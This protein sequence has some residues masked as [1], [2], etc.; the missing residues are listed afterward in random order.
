MSNTEDPIEKRSITKNG[1]FPKQSKAFTFIVPIGMLI[2]IG[3]GI[4]VRVYFYPLTNPRISASSDTHASNQSQSGSPFLKANVSPSTNI[5]VS[6]APTEMQN[7]EITHA[8]TPRISST[9]IQP[10]STPVPQPSVDDTTQLGNTFENSLGLKFVK[11]PNTVTYFC[12]WDTR[13]CDYNQFVSQTGRTWKEAGFP[14]SSD[15]PAVRISYIDAVAFCNWLTQQ[16]HS[17]EKLPDSLEYRLP[18]DLEW[19]VA[20]GVPEEVE[21]PP[22]WR[23]GAI[24]NCFAWGS[25]FPPPVGSGNYDPKLKT[26][27]YPYTSRVGSFRENRYGLFDMNGNVQ[28]WVLDDY[29]DSGQ[30]CLR[31]GS[32]ADEDQDGL[33][34]TT[35]DNEKKDTAYKV[36]G[37]RCVLAPIN[38]ISKIST[39][40]ITPASS[41][42]ATDTSGPKQESNQLV[43]DGVSEFFKRW[44]NDLTSNNPNNIANNFSDGAFYCYGNGF[45]KR[46]DICED[47]LKLQKK[48]P[49]RTYSDI[50]VESVNVE[51]PESVAI[52]YHIDYQY[53][54]QKNATG[55][56][57]VDIIICKIDGKWFV[58]SFN[59]NVVRR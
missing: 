47:F 32:W 27:P 28:Q 39:K 34:L 5:A 21:G 35:R 55:S 30:G 1:P 44:I 14:Q 59:E 12:I 20:A 22:S 31:G 36:F 3:T 41:S 37:F 25:S 19:S 13:V 8:P 51:S 11:I 29:D 54:G 26:D 7:V 23:S 33:N 42:S 49:V 53:S 38:T 46:Q 40:A 9:P 24:T 58:T 17:S 15:H 4:A 57:N 50:T 6:P 16:E 18:S 56:S 48:Y 52:K 43:P 10:K 45:S 2:A